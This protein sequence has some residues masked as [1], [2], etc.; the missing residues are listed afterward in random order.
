MEWNQRIKLGRV[1]RAMA[2]CWVLWR[3]VWFSWEPQGLV[4]IQ[5]AE[6]HTLDLKHAAASA[7][8]SEGFLTVQRNLGDTLV[9]SH[10]QPS[11]KSFII[12]A[13]SWF[14]PRLCLY[15]QSESQKVAFYLLTLEG[16]DKACDSWGNQRL[17]QE[18]EMKRWVLLSLAGFS[19]WN[20]A[21]KKEL[22]A[23]GG[24]HRVT[25]V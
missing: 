10:I 20:C 12:S 18:G 2:A 17:S 7:V 11:D 3:W 23:P 13:K 6:E 8:S 24:V 16:Q 1:Y 19:S 21:K 4:K 15:K 25:I 22:P 9:A 14:P 5:R